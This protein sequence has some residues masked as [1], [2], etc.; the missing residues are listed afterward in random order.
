MLREE[1]GL[2]ATL[3]PSAQ[4]LDSPAGVD[5][6]AQLAARGPRAAQAPQEYELL[7]EVIYEGYLLHYGERRLVDTPDADLAL[8]AGDQLYA[9]GLARL[10]TLGDVTA[11]TEL[12]DVITLSALAHGE[13]KRELALAVWEAGARAVG[14]GPSAELE[15]AKVL[16]RGGSPGALQ[17]LRE[18]AEVSSS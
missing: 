11:V 5:G 16:T 17:A 13:G 10:V 4:A 3:L 15:Q 12:A 8:L 7:L 9:L 14:W 18:A 6:P 2:I 1:G